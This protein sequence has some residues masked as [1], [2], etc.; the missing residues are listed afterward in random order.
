MKAA[1]EVEYEIKAIIG[2]ANKGRAKRSIVEWAE[3]CGG[4]VTIEPADGLHADLIREYE[5]KIEAAHAALAAV[6]A[7]TDK[8]DDMDRMI[9]EQIVKQKVSGTV[10][11]WRKGVEEEFEVGMVFIT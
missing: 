9:A 7:E 5:L 6:H 4:G 10:S 2:R 1:A 3:S 11:D 8:V